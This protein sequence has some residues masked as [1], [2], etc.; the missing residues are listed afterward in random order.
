MPNLQRH[1]GV[2]LVE[3]LVVIIV[4]SILLSLALAAMSGVRGRAGYAKGLSTHRQVGAALAMYAADAREKFPF[5]G[6]EH[7][8]LGPISGHGVTIPIPGAFFPV[9][10]EYWASVVVP[11]YFADRL[12]IEPPTYRE[13]VRLVGYPDSIV[14]SVLLLSGT[15]AAEPAFWDDPLPVNDERLIRGLGY[16]DVRHPSLKGITLG[17]SDHPRGDPRTGITVMPTGLGDGS[18]RTVDVFL[19]DDMWGIARPYGARPM[20][21]LST[22]GGLWGRDF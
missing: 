5:I 7:N 14:R 8:P 20:R 19:G 1:S 18:A 22:R 15:T 9:H 21:V 16:P 6:T 4:I 13:G 11:E 3:L 2:S 10:E 12:A 17:G